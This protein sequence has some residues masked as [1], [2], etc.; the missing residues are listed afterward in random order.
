[1]SSRLASA[2][3]AEWMDMHSA[4][5]FLSAV[6]VAEIE[7]GITKLRRKGARR[8]SADLAAWLEA[9]RHLY[10]ARILAFDMAKRVLPVPCRIGHAARAMRRDSATLSLPRPRNATA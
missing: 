9:V 3:L 4:V 10:D 7:D 2:G 6:T 8:K 5:L 1:M